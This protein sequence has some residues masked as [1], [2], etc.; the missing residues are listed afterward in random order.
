M[1]FEIK[2][3]G[4]EKVGEFP[5]SIYDMVFTKTY[6]LS[7]LLNEIKEPGV[8]TLM[9]T[10]MDVY[11]SH[12][13]QREP[14]TQIR[15]ATKAI[16]EPPFIHHTRCYH[17][18]AVVADD[19]EAFIQRSDPTFCLADVM[20][21]LCDD[22]HVH[23]SKTFPSRRYQVGNEQPISVSLTYQKKRRNAEEKQICC[24]TADD[25]YDPSVET[26]GKPNP[27]F[28]VKPP[29]T[30]EEKK[31]KQDEG[32][33][34][35]QRDAVT[36][37]RTHTAYM[38]EKFQRLLPISLLPIF[39]MYMP[40]AYHR[41]NQSLIACEILEKNLWTTVPCWK[42][43]T[44]VNEQLGAMAHNRHYVSRLPSKDLSIQLKHSELLMTKLNLLLEREED[45]KYDDSLLMLLNK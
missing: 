17:L 1:N 29:L 26:F 24:L 11:R 7:V 42:Y 6:T 14:S 8:T 27:R 12:G 43:D 28:Y 15:H 40:E 19:I 5:I 32:K 41:V 9:G 21:K 3:P 31:E 44:H 36:R 25:E 35:R 23:H 45:E 33:R 30:E 39:L 20:L 13:W 37:K 16:V 38:S 18:I 4:V 2:L 10:I 22:Y 34:D